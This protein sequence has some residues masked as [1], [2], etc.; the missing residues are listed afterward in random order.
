LN[1]GLPA[2]FLR[3]FLHLLK[4]FLPIVFSFRP[5]KAFGSAMLCRVL[6]IKISCSMDIHFGPEYDL[7]PTCDGAL[8]TIAP[9]LSELFARVQT[10]EEWRSQTNS[11]RR[12]FALHAAGASFIPHL[13]STT[14]QLPP[15]TLKSWIM[16]QLRGFDF[17]HVGLNPPVTA[18]EDDVGVGSCWA[19]S[20]SVGYIGINLAESVHITDISIY[21]V[22][23][24]LVSISE[25]LRAPR[26]MV[27]WGVIRNSHALPHGTPGHC[28]AEC[29][30]GANQVRHH[31][32]ERF[33]RLGD[34]SYNNTSSRR[35][36]TFPV[37][38]E[39][40]KSRIVF[41]RIVLEIL[42]NWGSTST[43]LY[44]IAA[45]GEAQGFSA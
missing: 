5:W 38:E 35:D 24:E 30:A 10:L 36:Q 37:S 9:G 14:Y 31:R 4:A 41:D 2:L 8:V 32:G 44:R 22:A 6:L 20:G 7:H 16:A 40:L 34:Y 28:T 45:Y 1:V 13:T 15:R 18:L 17:Q 25:F 3:S 29:F 43:C 21:H 33:L 19:F 23:P 27:V 12:N 42:D 11:A 26:T 39:L